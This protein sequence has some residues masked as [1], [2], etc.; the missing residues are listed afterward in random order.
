MSKIVVRKNI[1]VNLKSYSFSEFKFGKG[2]KIKFKGSSEN[3]ELENWKYELSIDGDFKIIRFG[4]ETQ[5]AP[6]QAESWKILVDFDQEEIYKLE[7]DKSGNL[8]IETTKGNQLIVED[9]PYENW[10]LRSYKV[11]DRKFLNNF[12]I[13]GG[14][15]NTSIFEY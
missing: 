12:H 15:G 4:K 2:V 3:A 10:H 9:G 5:C 13:I 7:A 11:I 6:Y 8:W 14:V 1:S